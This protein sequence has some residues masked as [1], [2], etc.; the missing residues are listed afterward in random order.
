MTEKDDRIYAP[1]H[2]VDGFDARLDGDENRGPLLL[3]VTVAVLLAFAAVVYT[4]YHQGLRKG[5]REAAPHITAETGPYKAMPEEDHGKPTPNLGN[6]AYEPLDDVTAVPVEKVKTTPLVEEPM[7]RPARMQTPP[8]E[9]GKQVIQRMPSAQEVTRTETKLEPVSET[10]PKTPAVAA[11]AAGAFVVQIAAF[12]SEDQALAAWSRLSGKL[13]AATSG[14]E[15]DVQ[16][17]D[18][19]ERGVYYRLRAASFVDRPTAA[20]FCD[21]LKKS[22]Q[23][24]LVVRR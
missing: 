21:Q 6:K 10:K 8:P 19:G 15:A 20:T 14:L 23:D 22:G 3:V 18:L 4:A 16:R 1:S 24:C 13:E 17:A 5:G 9:T 2:D 11:S 7:P 12:R